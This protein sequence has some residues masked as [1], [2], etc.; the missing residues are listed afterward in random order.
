VNKTGTVNTCLLSHYQNTVMT[1]LVCS[2]SKWHV[3]EN[4]HP[5]EMTAARV[6]SG[7]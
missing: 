1:A 4:E 7:E 5:R 3:L 2:V 6:T